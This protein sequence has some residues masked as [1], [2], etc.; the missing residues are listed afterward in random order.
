MR[1]LA[2]LDWAAEP[3]RLTGLSLGHLQDG[4][5]APSLFQEP[6]RDHSARVD[7]VADQIRERFGAEGLMRAALLPVRARNA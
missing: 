2:R 3:V 5:P 1:A 4:P 6:T 7:R